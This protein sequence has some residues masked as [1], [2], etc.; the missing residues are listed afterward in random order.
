MVFAGG[1]ALTGSSVYALQSANLE[2]SRQKVKISGI[3]KPLRIVALSDLHDPCPYVYVP[4]LIKTINL[5]NPDLFIMAGDIFSTRESEKLISKLGEINADCMKL[6]V[7]GNW[8][9]RIYSSF[10]NLRC[11]FGD[12]GVKFLVNEVCE[13][14]GITVIGLDDLLRGSPDFNMLKTVSTGPALNIVVSHCPGSFDHLK[15]YSHSHKQT[16]CISGHTHGGQIAPFGRVL[17]TPRGSGCYV[18][19]W[20]HA[21]N[22]SMYV[23][24][25]VGTSVFPLRIGARPELLVLDLIP[26][27]R[28][29]NG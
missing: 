23:M 3:D 1:T 8:E 29:D 15:S 25:G 12:A 27:K 26:G 21:Q 24:R 7:P 19:G 5:E 4:D 2:I 13:I 28:G 16:I 9:Y 6:A 14:Q 22:N 17:V 20:Y 11:R 18:Q 10:K